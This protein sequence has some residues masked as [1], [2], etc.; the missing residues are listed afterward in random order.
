MI[1]SQK[2]ESIL[3]IAWKCK[4]CGYVY[5]PRFGDAKSNIPKGTPFEE[6]P[7]T[8]V[9]PRCGAGKKQ[10]EQIDIA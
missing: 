4:K 2:E 5:D 8:W 1:I 10:F 6:I 7:D 3:T 9:C